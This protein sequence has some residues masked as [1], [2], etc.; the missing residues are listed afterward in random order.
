MR[1]RK[2]EGRLGFRVG[3]FLD[4]CNIAIKHRRMM[5]GLSCQAVK[6]T[7][8]LIHAV[9]FC[10]VLYHCFLL[11]PPPRFVE[12]EV[13][14]VKVLFDQKEG[15]LRSERD[16]AQRQLERLQAQQEDREAKVGSWSGSMALL[17]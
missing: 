15:R 3:S 6:G 13:E 14:R 1:A 5:Q 8:A 7:C 9:G 4:L 11:S 10:H 2:R 17:C 12:Q 16:A